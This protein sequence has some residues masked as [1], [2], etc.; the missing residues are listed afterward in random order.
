ML[1]HAI[2]LLTKKDL[3]CDVLILNEVLLID[4]NTSL[5]LTIESK[6]SKVATKTEKKIYQ[7]L[8]RSD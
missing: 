1:F 8:S 3:R 7:S 4:A 5:Y 2:C 6:K